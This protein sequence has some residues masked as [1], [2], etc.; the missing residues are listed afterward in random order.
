MITNFHWKLGSYYTRQTIHCVSS[1]SLVSP[2][3]A[4]SFS[5]SLTC[6]LGLFC[7]VDSVYALLNLNERWKYHLNYDFQ[8]G[9]LFIAFL[10]HNFHI[11]IG[12]EWMNNGMELPLLS[13]PL[14]IRVHFDNIHTFTYLLLPTPSPLTSFIYISI[15]RNLLTDY[16]FSYSNSRN[17]SN[18]FINVFI[19]S[20]HP[21]SQP[22]YPI[23]MRNVSCHT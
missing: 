20:H 3:R 22:I 23:S 5:L 12:I 1:F 8:Y 10:S 16:Q 21:V 11:N 19:D 6:C 4:R 9:F 18:C 13:P 14:F 7:S 17:S 2:V 15:E